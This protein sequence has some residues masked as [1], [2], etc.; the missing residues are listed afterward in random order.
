MDPKIEGVRPWHVQ[1]MRD[2]HAARLRV[3]PQKVARRRLRVLFARQRRR[4]IM[5]TIAYRGRGLA[6]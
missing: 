4:H 2:D 5:A 1:R 3:C 6:V